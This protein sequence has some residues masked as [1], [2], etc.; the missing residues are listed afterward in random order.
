MSRNYSFFQYNF[1]LI[2]YTVQLHCKITDIFFQTQ[3]LS[4][5]IVF[6]H[7][8]TILFCNILTWFWFF[9]SPPWH[10]FTKHLRLCRNETLN[11]FRILKASQSAKMYWVCGRT[12]SGAREQSSWCWWRPNHFSLTSPLDSPLCCSAA[13]KRT[14][15]FGHG[16]LTSLCSGRVEKLDLDAYINNHLNPYLN[17]SWQIL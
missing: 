16:Q 8:R 4:L 5:W 10:S 1:L 7:N 13:A 15:G 3:N 11:V 6:F 12:S 2:K 17:R 9:L 14:G